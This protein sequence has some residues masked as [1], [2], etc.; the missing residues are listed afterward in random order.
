MSIN[1]YYLLKV[2]IIFNLGKYKLLEEKFNKLK[3][4]YTKLREE[5]ITL[6]RQVTRSF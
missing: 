1:Y 6:L 4:V 3:E 5:H 2:L